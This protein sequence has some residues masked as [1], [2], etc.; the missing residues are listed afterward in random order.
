MIFWGS[1]RLKNPSLIQFYSGKKSHKNSNWPF[2][3]FD[4]FPKAGGAFKFF[5]NQVLLQS[6]TDVF[7]HRRLLGVM[8]GP[9]EGVIE[10]ADQSANVLLYIFLPERPPVEQVQEFEFEI[11]AELIDDDVVGM[12]VAVVFPQQMNLL[13]SPRER[14]Q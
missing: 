7:D 14:V 4:M 6:A 12:Q 5:Q 13:D 3:G 11:Q 8:P 1:A 2:E 10:Q 9:T